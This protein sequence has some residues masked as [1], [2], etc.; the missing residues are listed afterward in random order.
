M[1][2]RRREFQRPVP[3]KVVV[4]PPWPKEPFVP[5]P[6]PFFSEEQAALLEKAIPAPPPPPKVV[7]IT[8]TQEIKNKRYKNIELD[9]GVERTNKELGLRGM[10]IVADSMTIIKAEADFEYRLN[11]VSND[12]TP[13]EKGMTEDE[14]EIEEIYIT[15]AAAAGK[16]AI[17][18][19]NWNPYLIRPK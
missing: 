12:A 7:P 9:L 2:S 5:A 4:E 1:S 6:E 19:V 10:G 13:A 3:T 14:I 15:N 17:I 8:L 16:T 11:S 18:R